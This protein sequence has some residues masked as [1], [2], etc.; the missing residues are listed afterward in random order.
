M[1][2]LEEL[3]TAWLVHLDSLVLGM[4]QPGASIP[5]N[6]RTN[7]SEP[8]QSRERPKVTKSGVMIQFDEI[9]AQLPDSGENVVQYAQLMTMTFPLKPDSLLDDVIHQRVAH[10][11]APV[12]F[13]KHIAEVMAE[14]FKVPV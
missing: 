12:L 9:F 6:F 2:E 14:S 8:K 10:V 3:V 4:V 11:E 1:Q 7:G 13:K 5:E